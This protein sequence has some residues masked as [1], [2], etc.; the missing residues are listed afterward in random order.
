MAKG[1]MTR[2]Q[3]GPGFEIIDAAPAGA[4]SVSGDEMS[5][6]M[7]GRDRGLR[8]GETLPLAATPRSRPDRGRRPE[9]QGRSLER[10]LQF[11]SDA[12]GQDGQGLLHLAQLAYLQA[13]V[14]GFF[15]GALEPGAGDQGTRQLV[16]SALR[17]RTLPERRFGS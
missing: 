7:T 16:Q 15:G 14:G 13:I 4:L 12:T 8:R 3:S 11:V 17:R 10:Q 1:Y 6:F 9:R 2:D 5:H